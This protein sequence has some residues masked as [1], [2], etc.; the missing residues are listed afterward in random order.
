MICDLISKLPRALVAALAIAAGALAACGCTVD[1]GTGGCD[2]FIPMDTEIGIPSGRACVIAQEGN[3]S[4]ATTELTELTGP[5]CNT[6]CGL[7]FAYCS[8]PGDFLAA[9][10]A[11]Q[12]GTEEAGVS[13]TDASAP[14]C[15]AL[16]PTTYFQL[17]CTSACSQ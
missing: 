8:L 14:G 4:K 17:T 2:G 10:V 11:A 15:P 9:Y 1:Q 16:A 13:A 3:V 7:P 12:S 6:T 5:T